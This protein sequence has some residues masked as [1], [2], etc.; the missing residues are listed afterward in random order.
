MPGPPDSR[1]RGDEPV[2]FLRGWQRTAA[3][4]CDERALE[5]HLADLSLASRALL[6]S[7]AGP[8][9]AR[10]FTVLPTTEDVTI[11]SSHFRVLLLRRL[12]LPLQLGSRACSCRG[13]LD[14]YGDHRAACATSGA[15]ASR[16][17]PIERA[18][19]RVCQEAG[20]RVR[21][22]VALSAMTLD[23]PVYDS[24]R[25]KHRGRLQRP[26]A[27]AR[28]TARSRCHPGQPRFPGRKITPWH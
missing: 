16:A 27:V 9:S 23:V 26:T 3:H 14:E 17:V 5:T 2:D 12:R 4:A 21:R 18:I 13:A 10:A 1:S 28:R 24:R 25:I 19:A 7:Q 22:N 8:H 11:P 6:L 20:A 15:L